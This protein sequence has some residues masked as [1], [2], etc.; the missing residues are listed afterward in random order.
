M[1]LPV[2][3]GIGASAGGVEALQSFFAATPPDCGLT[4]VVY[5]HFPPQATSHLV[6]ILA[7][8]S[9][10]PVTAAIHGETVQPNHVYV[11]PPGKL[12]MFANGGITLSKLNEAR[13]PIDTMFTSL[14]S[15]YG[16]RAIGVV[17]SGTGRDGAR[18]IEAISAGDGLTVAQGDGEDG[19]S[20]P[21]MPASA[22]ATG[23]VDYVMRIE[24]MP[25]HLVAYGNGLSSG[26]TVEAAPDRLKCIKDELCRLL[27]QTAKHDFTRYKSS[28]FLRRV[29]RRMRVL[30]ITAWDAYVDHARHNPDEVT[31]LFRDLL[32]GVTA[33]FRD[34]EAFQAL[35]TT[36]IPRLFAGKGGRDVV[37]VWVPGCSSGEEAYSIAMLLMEYAQTLSSPP[38]LQVFATDVDEAALRIARSGSYSASALDDLREDRVERFFTRDGD[39]FIAVR[40]L[41]M[42]CTFSLHS[43]IRDPP[44]TSIDLISCRN[45]L[46]YFDRTL[47]DQV[48]QT[49]HFSLRPG[50]ILFLGPSENIGRHTDLFA[51]LD[52]TNRI[53]EHVATARRSVPFLPPSRALSRPDLPV[54]RATGGERTVAQMADAQILKRYGPANV[55]VNARG[56]IVH[57][58]SRTGK[59]LEP[60]PGSPNHNLLAMAR[61]GL[62]ASLRSALHE[63]KKSGRIAV[64]DNVDVEVD[65]GVVQ[66]VQVAVE[67]LEQGGEAPLWLVTFVDIG[68]ILLD[69][70]GP[71]DD[72]SLKA[73]MAIQLLERELQD[74][75]ENL[76]TAI[77]EYEIAVEELR[78]SNEE[79]MAMNDDLQASNEELEA[80]KEEL[81]VANDELCTV[82]VEL[83]AKID[84]LRLA[85]DDLRNIFNSTK[86]AIIILDRTLTIRSFTPTATEMFR[87]VPNDIGRL[88]TDIVIF[89]EYDTLDADMA[90]ALQTR[91]TVE[92]AV[93]RRDGGAHYLLHVIPYLT[94]GGEVDGVLVTLVNVTAAV[95]AQAQERYHRLLIAELNHRVKN[96]LAVA[97]SLATQSLRNTNTA[98]DFTSVFL[99]RLQALS[100]A[101]DLL[102]NENWT[103][104][105]LRTLVMAGLQLQAERGERVTLDGPL[106]RL[107]PKAATTLS[108]AFHELATNA[109]KYGAFS[110]DKGRIHIA[111]AQ[112][113]RP[114][115]A[116]LVIRWRE[117]GGPPVEPPTR[118]GFGS[119]MIE[120]GIKYELRGQ[121][122]MDFF[123]AG[124]EVEISMPLDGQLP[125]RQNEGTS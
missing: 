40:E 31:R 106:I 26:E 82:N 73:D 60:I 80:S 121:A 53:F 14:A 18:G 107:N 122:K 105:P 1:P 32:I 86:I 76:Q 96:I 112:E 69:Q 89:F 109:T 50:G 118:K 125:A 98:A 104:V 92:R 3:V 99:G 48:I 39:K 94:L 74:T 58:S 83:D 61:K 91:K 119:E 54:R 2:I 63:A 111:W 77:D 70:V 45:L 124:L 28:T 64:I 10:L 56:D 42:I 37:R 101:H 27:L 71:K 103:D 16:E 90:A 116:V 6:G 44:L 65:A 33:F 8:S 21:E 72:H 22:I 79:L 7:R 88:L 29:G 114:D 102:S 51:P 85:N 81:F 9:G 95:E 4:F 30:G 12:A 38:Q 100:R 108:L 68:P 20:H 97:A 115:G 67:P 93:V 13:D 75:R 15:E 41:R 25:A 120:R 5:L 17:L 59:Y 36:I 23:L 19:S 62:R 52:S 46:I 34:P 84:E 87:L 78:S 113:M 35:A 49:F 24:E 55:V 123:P 110:N 57:F 66:K 11:V 47:Q 117:S 43:L